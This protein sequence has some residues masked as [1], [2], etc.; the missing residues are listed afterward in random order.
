MEE[1]RNTNAYVAMGHL[2]FQGF[3]EQKGV[4]STHGLDPKLFEKFDAVYSGHFHHRH[5]QGNIEY[6]GAFAEYTWADYNDDRG[7]C[8]FDTDTGEMT[9]IKNPYSMF[10]MMVYE[11]EKDKRILDTIKNMD[12]SK[13]ANSFVRVIVSNKT[14][15]YAFGVL[16]EKLEQS[17]QYDISVVEDVSAFAEN[18]EGSEIDETED[19]PTIFNKYIDGLTLG[20]DNDRLKTTM[21]SLYKEAITLETI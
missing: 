18:E 19:T 9:F 7:F 3:Q 5:K 11:D 14:N 20:I 21:L 13:Y 10:H 1:I 15:P 2:E 4:L 8:I 6:I 17:Q 16:L 12:S